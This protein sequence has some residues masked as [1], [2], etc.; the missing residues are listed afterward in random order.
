VADGTTLRS[1]YTLWAVP[2]GLIAVGNTATVDFGTPLLWA[3]SDGAAWSPVQVMDVPGNAAITSVM[4]WRDRLIAVGV[5]GPSDTPSDDGGA[6]WTS[7]DGMTWQQHGVGGE[8]VVAALEWDD[9]L[10]LVGGAGGPRFVGEP[11]EPRRGAIWESGDGITF[12]Q[13]APSPALAGASVRG[14][15]IADGTLVLIGSF[16]D[17]ETGQGEPAIWTSTDGVSWDARLDGACCGSVLAAAWLGN[18]MVAAASDDVTGQ[19]VIYR[20]ADLRAW[21]V[22]GVLPDAVGTPKA[23]VTSSTLGPLLLVDGADGSF[24]L[25]PPG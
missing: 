12:E 9:G 25:A 13:Q 14:A 1:A 10:I 8:A 3:S 18:A 22:D 6:V 17:D 2:D 4:E 23:F 16:W 7:T 5:S 21:N 20:S 24:L 11:R 19:V 15:V